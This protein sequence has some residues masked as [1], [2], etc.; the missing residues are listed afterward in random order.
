MGGTTPLAEGSVKMDSRLSQC[1]L[2]VVVIMLAAGGSATKDELILATRQGQTKSVK[3]LPAEGANVNAK[4]LVGNST[5]MLS[6]GNGH[7]V[8]AKNLIANGVDVNAKT[9][10]D[11]A[12]IGALFSGQTI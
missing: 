12:S 4:A 11:W 1:L 10:G 6:T 3:V 7:L 2:G 5:L 9:T 8:V